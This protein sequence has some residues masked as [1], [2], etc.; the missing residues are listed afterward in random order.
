[1][2][3]RGLVFDGDNGLEAFQKSAAEGTLPEVSWI[4]PPGI[5]QEHPPRSPVDGS[6]YINQV[7]NATLHGKN[8]NDTI[9][10]INYDGKLR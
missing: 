7:V 3:K 1:M 4:F 6:W 5:L 10:M 2:Y 8:Y 9:F